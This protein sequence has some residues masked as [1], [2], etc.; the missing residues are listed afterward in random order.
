M[1]P[2]EGN[3]GAQDA[4][5]ER[6]PAGRV[7][8]RFARGQG[9]FAAGRSLRRACLRHK[10]LR[11]ECLRHECLRRAGRVRPLVQE[12]DEMPLAADLVRIEMDIAALRLGQARERKGDWRQL[13]VR[14]KQ[15][16]KHALVLRVVEGAGRIDHRAAGREH[17]AGAFKDLKLPVGAA[18]RRVFAPLVPRLHLAAE[19]RRSRAR[20][21]ESCQRTPGSARRAHPAARW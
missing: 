12:R 6:G 2:R 20:R 15:P 4:L 7:L 18:A 14:V 21:R 13:G 16:G 1:Q 3:S 5:R 10:C 9:L 8:P 11:H 17:P 19:H